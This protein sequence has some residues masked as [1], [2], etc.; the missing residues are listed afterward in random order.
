MSSIGKQPPENYF[1]NYVKNYCD[2][3]IIWGKLT[4]TSIEILSGCTLLGY[5]FTIQA[6]PKRSARYFTSNSD[7]KA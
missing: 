7:L 5:V 1:K 2:D 4:G 6:I 3:M